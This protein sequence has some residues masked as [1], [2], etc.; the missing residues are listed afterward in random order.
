MVRAQAGYVGRRVPWRQLA[1]GVV[2]CAPLLADERHQGRLGERGAAARAGGVAHARHDCRLR[3]ARPLVAGDRGDPA[4]AMEPAIHGGGAHVRRR[5]LSVGGAGV[6]GRRVHGEF[7]APAGPWR[8]CRTAGDV[9]HGARHRSGDAAHHIGARR[10]GVG[11]SG[12]GA[13]IRGD[14][15]GCPLAVMAVGR[16][17]P[18]VAARTP[19]VGST[20]GDGV[21][22]VR[23]VEPRSGT[24]GDARSA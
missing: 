19:A 10:A 5:R 18:T 14:A 17:R 22:G 11:G 21:R 7:L 24:P 9:H 20:G 8:V 6:A 2:L 16:A 4:R 12:A 3:I 15:D 1:G 13:R 23:L